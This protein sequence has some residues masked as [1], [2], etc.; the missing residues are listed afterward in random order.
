[1]QKRENQKDR[2]LL[3]AKGQVIAAMLLFGTIGVFVRG[4]NLPSATVALVRGAVGT[5]FLLLVVLL[6]GK[7]AR[8]TRQDA[9]GPTSA[10][11]R[12]KGLDVPAIRENLVRL[13][14]SGAMIGFNWILLFEAYRYTTVATATLCYYLAPTLVVLLSPAILGE[15]LTAKRILCAV[16]ALIGMIPV[17]GVL[18]TGGIDAAQIRGVLC[19]IG[20]AALYAGVILMNKRLGS[21]PAMDRTIVQLGSAALVLLP[22]VLMTGE[23]SALLAAPIKSL[24]LLMV[25]AILH[26]G[27]AYAMYFGALKVLPAQTAAIL[28]YLDPVTAVLLSAL[29]L[30]EP[31]GIMGIIGAVLILGA[32]YVSEK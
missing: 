29:L 8:E 12:S 10:L 23:L 3:A 1:M 11:V 5:L 26:T 6:R 14:I 17:S 4:I 27:I 31:L 28:S 15:K 22:Y 9:D 2:R 30:G 19:G 16:V 21:V 24:V 7:F 25:V 32:A 18:Q 13:C 20:A